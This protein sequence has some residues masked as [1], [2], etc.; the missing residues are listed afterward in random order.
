MGIGEPAA[1]RCQAVDIGR[2]HPRCAIATDIAVTQIVR[3]DQDDIGILISGQGR[4]VRVSKC[5]S[6]DQKQ[7]RPVEVTIHVFAILI[8]SRGRRVLI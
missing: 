2:L 7:A 4:C 6:C 8:V 3:E 1:F 5:D